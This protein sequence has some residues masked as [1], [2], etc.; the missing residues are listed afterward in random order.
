MIKPHNINN[1]GCQSFDHMLKDMEIYD[2]DDGGGD[3]D[4]ICKVCKSSVVVL[5]VEMCKHFEV[6]LCTSLPCF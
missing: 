6:R 2:D 4:S 5:F 3:D 1:D